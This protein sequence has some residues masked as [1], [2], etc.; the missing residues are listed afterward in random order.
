MNHKH[1]PATVSGVASPS[2]STHQAISEEIYGRRKSRLTG[3][4]DAVLNSHRYVLSA[5]HQNQDKNIGVQS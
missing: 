4:G 5:V 2:L 3:A 1:P